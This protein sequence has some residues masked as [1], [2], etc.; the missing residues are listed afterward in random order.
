[1]NSAGE[2]SFPVPVSPQTSTVAARLVPTWVA[3]K[4]RGMQR[5]ALAHDHP[6]RPDRSSCQDGGLARSG[7]GQ[8][9]WRPPDPKGNRFGVSTQ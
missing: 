4:N 2:N 5:V 3:R 9:R 8:A 7:V 6:V 1:M